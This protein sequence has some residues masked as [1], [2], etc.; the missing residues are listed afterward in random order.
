MAD[1]INRSLAEWKLEMSFVVMPK[2]ANHYGNVHGGVIMKHADDIAYALASKFSRMNV[3]T[4]RLSELNFINPVKVGDM[5]ILSAGLVRVGKSS[6]DIQV[7]ITGDKLTSGEIFD[8]A[9]AHFTM[10]AVDE[11]G[12]PKPIRNV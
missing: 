8:V 1:K 12:K 7:R 6:M 5:V 10:V 4:A 2:D 9:N 11:Q 3:V